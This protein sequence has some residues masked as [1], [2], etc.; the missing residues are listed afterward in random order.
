[1]LFLTT[2]IACVGAAIAAAQVPAALGWSTR[3]VLEWAAL[4]GG[5]GLL[6]QFWIEV[7]HG[8]ERENFSLTDAPF[9]AALL[10][11]RPSVLTLGIAVGAA[12]GQSL[13]RV[14]PLKVAFNV[15]Q[16]IVGMTA[17]VAVYDALRGAGGFGADE[18]L[19]AIA[20]MGV[21]FL[22]NVSTVALVISLVEG[23]PFRRV[24]LS[25]LGL[26]V[27]H[28]AGNV[29][30]GL[31]AAVVVRAQPAALPLLVIPLGLSYLAYRGWIRSVQERTRMEG[32]AAAAAAISAEGDLSGRIPKAGRNEPVAFLAET[33]NNMLDRL[34][35]SFERERTFMSE[36][37]HELRTPITI[38]RGYLE[39][40][41]ADAPPEEIQ[42]TID[43]LV[44]E[45]SRMG[46]IVDDIT[47][48]VR[49]EDPA[50]LR[51]EQVSL[52]HFVDQVAAKAAPLVGGRLR[53]MAPPRPA[54][55]QVDPQRL[56][57]A[58]INL[59]Q[60]AVAH[61]D[62]PIELLVRRRHS[63]WR[64]EVSDQGVGLP[65]GEEENVFRPFHRAGSVAPGSGLGLAI[66]RGIA[67][68]HEGSAGVENRPGKGATFW[69]EVPV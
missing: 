20:G 69:I 66:V 31:L 61:G 32:M 2:A 42:E 41:R 68:A 54:E 26:S 58:L 30:L 48:L 4:A 40:L 55:V 65:A 12:V 10:L 17:A 21:Y 51:R 18:W 16:F 1:V 13:R 24:L 60:N 44:D 38:S 63:A 29:A 45:L 50:F 27:L 28:W 15:G 23:E 59:L 36:V 67:E 37:S 56:T 43:V 57:Q 33:L 19:A 11:V 62:G 52:G 22:V 34:E 9:A 64:F 5:V 8:S 35:A 3:N 7:R 25:S 14:A 47:T 46:R 53:V 39:V 6:E 49:S